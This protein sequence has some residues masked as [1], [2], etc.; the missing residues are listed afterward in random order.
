[1]VCTYILVLSSADFPVPSITALGNPSTN[2]KRI[3]CSTSGGFPKPHLS[4]LENEKELN[5]T[6]TTVSQDPESGLY[7]INSELDFNVESNHSFMCL[8]K[9]GDLTVSQIFNWQKCK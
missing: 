2:I 3:I 7:T 9:Y 4:W 6:N 5:A 8:V 1:M